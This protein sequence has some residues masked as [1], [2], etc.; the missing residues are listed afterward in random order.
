[1]G[2]SPPANIAIS[3]DEEAP[4]RPRNHDPACVALIDAEG[5]RTMRS[6]AES[7]SR[8]IEHGFVIVTTQAHCGQYTRRVWFTEPT[9]RRATP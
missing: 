2:R 9:D 1:M 7:S 3:L 5:A 8:N 6:P 4:R